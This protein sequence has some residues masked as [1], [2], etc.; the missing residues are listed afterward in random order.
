[1]NNPRFFSRRRF[2]QTAA[3]GLGLAACGSSRKYPEYGGSFFMPPPALDTLVFYDTE[4]PPTLDPARSWGYFD[5][6]LVG[7]VFSNLVKF[8]R[9]ANLQPDLAQSWQ[10]S[11]DGK[12]Y[13]FELNPQAHFSNGRPVN[14]EDV[15]YSFERVLDPKTDSSTRWVLAN[16]DE[17]E[18]LETKRLRLILKEPFA[19]FLYL[20]A[21]PAASIVPREEVE[22]CEERG[23]P[24]G[25]KPTGSG[26]W[27]FEE[28]QHDQYI[29]FRRNEEYWGPKPQVPKLNMRIIS[30]QFTAIAEFETGNIATI[31]PTPLSEINRWRTHPQWKHYALKYPMLNIDMLVF[32]CE[33]E[34]FD[35]PEIRQAFCRA[36]ETSLVLD[37]VRVGVGTVSTGPI[38]P[39]LDGHLEDREPYSYDLEY[40]REM[41]AKT[42]LP[43]R[44]VDLV[45]PSIE[46]YVR[47]TGVVMQ[48]LWKRL[49]IEVRLHQ[50]EWVTYRRYL[51]EGKFDLGWRNWY[52]DY[53]DGDN[54]IYPL[55]HSS[56]IGAGNMSRFADDEVDHLI[57]ASQQE[58]D[59]TRRKKLLEQ[60]N[61]LIYEKAPALFLWHQ[62]KYV[63]HQPWLQGNSEPLVFNG[64][65]Y[66][67]EKIVKPR[68]EEKAV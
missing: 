68:V 11:K 8:D 9:Q 19:P 60:V 56:Q 27:L 32:N 49:D 25:E 67:Q 64:I 29:A 62:A 37:C 43:Q 54:F 46:N 20:M 21:M 23:I 33:R 4:D 6:R 61:T 53:P 38:S 15:K 52:A 66:L 12:S 55:F 14:A 36:V 34:P 48:A 7:L 41:L 26:P 16:I 3:G 51:R 39:G 65:R 13:T 58:L 28:W 10:A 2:L 30:N 63:V 45:F 35:R 59:S 5:G 40:A 17:I 50:L 22:R 31:D 18:V 42:D 1:M 24:F 47:T 57:Q 44:G